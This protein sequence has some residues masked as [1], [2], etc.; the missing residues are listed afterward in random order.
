MLADDIYAEVL[1]IAGEHRTADIRVG[2]GYTA[3]ALDDGRCGLAFTLHEKEYE[4]CTVIPDAG[5]ERTHG[6][7]TDFLDEIARRDSLCNRACNGKCA[8]RRAER[9]GCSGYT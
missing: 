2:L 6:F 3:V 8:Y 9:R 7:G 5:T 1:A 4:S